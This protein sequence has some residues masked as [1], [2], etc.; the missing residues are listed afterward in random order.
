MQK[1]SLESEKELGKIL[2]KNNHIKMSTLFGIMILRKRQVSLAS[3]GRC[4]EEMASAPSAGGACP[5][6]QKQQA[7]RS[8]GSLLNA[9]P[10]QEAHDVNYKK[11]IIHTKAELAIH[12]D[13]REGKKPLE[14]EKPR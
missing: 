3:Q 11:L 1:Y 8:A 9:H 4:Q 2:A 5:S 10:P 14:G 12:K 13:H 6:K 7:R